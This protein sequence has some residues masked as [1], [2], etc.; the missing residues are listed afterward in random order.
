M[1]AH[2]RPYRDFLVALGLSVLNTIVVVCGFV[3][4]FVIGGY[5]NGWR[6]Y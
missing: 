3:G 5:I 4:A 6:P 1:I 2:H